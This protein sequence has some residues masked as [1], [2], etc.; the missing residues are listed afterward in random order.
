MS[1][2]VTRAELREELRNHPTNEELREI[3]AKHPTPKQL[4]AELDR[5]VTTAEQREQ[6]ARQREEMA[7]H[8][9]ALAARHDEDIART[10]REQENR[11]D[12]W[13]GGLVDRID[14]SKAELKAEL[15][16]FGRE[17]RA[18]LHLELAHHVTSFEEFTR[19]TIV[20]LDDKY[21]DLPPRVT[22]L[23]NKVFAPKRKRR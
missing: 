18:E 9:A 14:R 23:E 1:T 15:D 12:L 4:R 22:R 19:S 20:A 21:R 16:R 5:F 7:Q 11:T 3:L 13:G 6:L 10:R 17:L 8:I 2:P